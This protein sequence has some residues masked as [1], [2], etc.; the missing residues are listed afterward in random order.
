MKLTAN[1]NDTYFVTMT[2]VNWIDIFTRP[3]YKDLIIDNLEFCRKEKGLEIYS[4][5]IMTNHIHMIARAK[6]KPLSS[7]LRDFKTFTS[8]ELYMAIQSNAKES[9]SKWIIG[10]LKKAGDE[11]RLNVHHQ[12]WRN[13]NQPILISNNNVFLVKQNYIHQNPVRAGFV[14]NDCDYLYSSA[15]EQSPLKVDEY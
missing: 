6:K 5:V 7:V 10:L 2:V 9:R 1:T 13:Y 11:N 4:Y 8:K 3:V 15:C 12:F 14:V